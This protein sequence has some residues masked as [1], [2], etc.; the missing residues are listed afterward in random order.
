MKKLAFHKKALCLCSLNKRIF[1]LLFFLSNHFFFFLSFY[2]LDCGFMF[3]VFVFPFMEVISCF[4]HLCFIMEY[5][6]LRKT[7]TL[8]LLIQ[9]PKILIKFQRI[10]VRKNAQFKTSINEKYHDV[11]HL[12][13]F[14]SLM[15]KF[16]Q[17]ISR[18]WIS[19]EIEHPIQHRNPI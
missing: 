1:V 6:C 8:E 14:Q 2:L 13:A 18:Y 7:R 12:C 9:S 16:G 19:I 4:F 11:N 15:D 10:L 3:V 17:D 5:Y